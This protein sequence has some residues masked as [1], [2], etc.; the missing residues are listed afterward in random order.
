ML[1]RFR[2]GAALHELQTTT[3]DIGTDRGQRIHLPAADT[4]RRPAVRKRY[5]EEQIIAI[6]KEHE[7]GASV[8]DLAR[9][10]ARLASLSPLQR[11][12]SCTEYSDSRREVA[13]RSM[14]GI[15][16]P[17]ELIALVG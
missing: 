11:E 6:L 14:R 12:R 1:E 8:P 16:T 13:I 9:R 2:P 17:P 10:H 7:A 15:A 3:R 5:T 4:A